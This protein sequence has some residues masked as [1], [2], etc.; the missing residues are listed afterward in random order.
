MWP[1]AAEKAMPTVLLMRHGKSDW[2]AG[3]PDHDRPLNRRGTRAAELMGAVLRRLGD[4]P[5]HVVTSSA[6]RARTTAELAMA[7]GGF[8]DAPMKVSA[9]LYMPS[10]DDVL[11]VLAG[12]PDDCERALVVGHQPTWGHAAEALTGARLRFVTAAVAAIEVRSF[13]D[14]RGGVLRWF[15]PPRDAERLRP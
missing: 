1:V 10:V 11:D 8:G 12:L 5:T 3:R 6:A 4:V 13:G 14:P 2:S 15:L 7:G 9:Q